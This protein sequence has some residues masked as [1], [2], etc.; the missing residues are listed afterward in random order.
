MLLL[1]Q[2]PTVPCLHSADCAVPQWLEW[3]TEKFKKRK[4]WV[5][6][7]KVVKNSSWHFKCHFGSQI[8]KIK[9]WVV[10]P[11]SAQRNAHAVTLK[12]G[13]DLDQSSAVHTRY[14]RTLITHFFSSVAYF[15]FIHICY[16]GRAAE[17]RAHYTVLGLGNVDSTGWLR[18]GTRIFCC[19][20]YRILVC[21]LDTVLLIT[22][23]RYSSH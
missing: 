14:W 1:S 3:W 9:G 22:K 13:L 16:R 19:C 6:V 5:I 4:K 15:C 11:T 20:Q 17:T 23:H 7:R 2:L 18:V 10:L 8:I 12:L 21:T